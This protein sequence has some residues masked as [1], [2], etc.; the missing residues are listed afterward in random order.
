MNVKLKN[1]IRKLTDSG[2]LGLL[3][4]LG[5]ICILLIRKKGWLVAYMDASGYIAFLVALLLT[6]K[7]GKILENRLRGKAFWFFHS[8]KSFWGLVFWGATF[9]TYVTIS[10]LAVKKITGLPDYILFPCSTPPS[11]EI[12]LEQAK[13]FW[14]LKSYQ[15]FECDTDTDSGAGEW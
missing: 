1:L 15:N 9:Y 4:F 7:I 11:S 10:D 3:G 12:Q 8:A 14:K 5:I 2:L 13:E 6:L